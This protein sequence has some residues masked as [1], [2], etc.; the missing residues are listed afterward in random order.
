MKLHQLIGDYMREIDKIKKSERL[1][2]R[3]KN[4]RIVLWRRRIRRIVE[5]LQKGY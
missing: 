4:A 3:K 1:T 5:T 2:L